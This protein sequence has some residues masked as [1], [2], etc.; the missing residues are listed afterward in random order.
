MYSIS[1]AD[2]NPG[3]EIRCLFDPWIRDPEWVYSGSR[4]SDPGSQTHIFESL[5]TTFWVKSFI[6][7]NSLKFGPNFFLEQLKNKQTGSATLYSML[8]ILPRLK[9]PQVETGLR[10]RPL[11]PNR[12]SFSNTA[13]KTKKKIW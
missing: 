1:V 6:N 3:S 5:V 4:I 2:P 10:R 13:K 12:L 9:C 7:D 8:V 11:L